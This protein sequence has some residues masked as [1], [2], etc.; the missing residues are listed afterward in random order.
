MAKRTYSITPIASEDAYKLTGK[1]LL[2]YQTV[3]HLAQRGGITMPEVGFYESAEANAFATGMTKNSS[4]VA[5][6]SG[7]LEKMENDAIV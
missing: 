3:Q 7:L 5:V 6:S 1:E 2:V 4:L